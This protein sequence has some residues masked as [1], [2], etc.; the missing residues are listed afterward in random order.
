[1]A[2]MI[3]KLFKLNGVS[4]LGVKLQIASSVNSDVE[5][6]VTTASTVLHYAGTRQLILP[7]EKSLGTRDEMP[8]LIRFRYANH[9]HNSLAI[10]G[11]KYLRY[12]ELT[13]KK[14]ED[15]L[16]QPEFDNL[17]IFDGILPLSK[18]PKSI[19]NYFRF[20]KNPEFPQLY[21]RGNWELIFR[22]IYESIVETFDL[23]K[24]FI[25]NG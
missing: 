20:S 24:K 2:Q 6:I 1:M 19:T 16:L 3:Q 14:L 18:L 17:H 15:L 10:L 11:E 8:T 5:H 21:I 23:N 25:K 7:R 4:E 9:P 22:E 13:V 12:E